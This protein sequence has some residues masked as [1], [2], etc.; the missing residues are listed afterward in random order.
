ME[1][2]NLSLK[3][4]FVEVPITVMTLL[5]PSMHVQLSN[6]LLKYGYRIMC[7]DVAY[8]AKQYCEW[9]KGNLNENLDLGF[10]R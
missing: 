5:Y 9:Q 4:V 1:L 7:M 8:M 10:A 2:N 3:C 6:A